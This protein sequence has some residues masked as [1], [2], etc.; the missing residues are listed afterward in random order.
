LL[1]RDRL[2]WHELVRGRLLTDF[3]QCVTRFT[4]RGVA[5]SHLAAPA[6][7]GL[8]SV[9]RK[10]IAHNGFAGASVGDLPESRS[11]IYEL[12]DR[13]DVAGSSFSF[14]VFD[15]SW[16]YVHGATLRTLISGNVLDVGPTSTPAY[17]GSTATA[18]RSF[19]RQFDADPAEVERDFRNG[20][21]R[22]YFERTNIMPKPTDMP[23]RTVPLEVANRN[24][25]EQNG[26][27]TDLARRLLKNAAQ[28]MAMDGDR[29]ALDQLQGKP[30]GIDIDLARRRLRNYE[31]K[32]AIDADDAD[33]IAELDRQR[34]AYRQPD[35]AA[36]HRQ[37][38]AAILAEATRRRVNQLHQAGY[39]V[40]DTS[41]GART[42][43]P[44]SPPA[45]AAPRQ[46]VPNDGWLGT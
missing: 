11:D 37:Q 13:G 36:Q 22:R 33:A 44:P 2:T 4:L 23:S 20:S 43:H 6:I 27:D 18:Y 5:S 39:E 24:I 26:M 41:S 17:A 9:N 46:S 1:D 38:Q 29:P 45:V 30:V 28:K 7:R 42:V 21:T 19:A 34:D 14:N 10:L 25:K 8:P 32:I 31:Q 12:V 40:I 16:D 15:D 35:V 3:G